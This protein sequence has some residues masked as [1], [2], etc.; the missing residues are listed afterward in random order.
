MTIRNREL[1]QFGSFI[2]IDNN[3][4]DIGITTGS[5]PYVGIGTTNAQ[6]KLH[7]VGNTKLEGNLET[8]DANIGSVYIQ[9]NVG[10]VSAT[11]ITVVNPIDTNVSTATSLE[12]SRNFSIIGDFIT[13]PQISFNGTS[14]VSLAATITENSIELG[15]YTSGDYVKTLTGTS[16]QILVS[17]GTGEG[18]TP[19]ASL[20]SSLQLPG[21]LYVTGVSTF[22]GISTFTGDLYTQDVFSNFVNASAFYVNGNELVEVSLQTWSQASGNDIYRQ[23]GNVGIGTSTNLSRLSVNGQIESQASQGTAPFIVRSTTLVSNLN[24]SLLS[25]KSA[26]SGDLVGTTAVQTL[27]NKTFN[28]ASNTLSGNLSQFNTALSDADFASLSG[29]ETLTNKTLTTPIITSIS[30]SGIQTV[31]SG[32]GLLIST[33]SIGL[34]NRPMLGN[35]QLVDADIASNADIAFSKISTVGI[36]NSIVNDDISNGTIQNVKLVN[37]TISGISLGSN[38]SNLVP[39]TYLS[40]NNYN[41]ST[42]QTWNV[43]ATSSNTPDTIISRDSNGDFTAGTVTA[44][45]FNSTSDINLKTNIKKIDN[46]LDITNKLCGVSFDW[47]ETGK[48]SYGVIAQELEKVLPDLVKTKDIKSVNYNGLIGILIEA[49]KELS[50]EVQELKTQLNR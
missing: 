17:N 20:S 44:T 39:G 30:N 19:T 24:A 22:T 45:D 43:N 35:L 47:K 41:G 28:L 4:K 18:S 40:G 27:T 50:D 15:T 49:V 42:E 1:S 11:S 2:Y 7:V 46:A 25:G 37:S 34:I 9:G 10:L 32:N 23:V 48:K 29:V 16:N 12:T 31:P 26:P 13:S 14:N 38:L 3:T 36:G 5:V 8:N 33:N 6:K 21:D